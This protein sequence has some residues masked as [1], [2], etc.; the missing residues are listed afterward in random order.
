MHT[1]ELHFFITAAAMLL[2]SGAVIVSR[3]T[4]EPAGESERSSPVGWIPA[5]SAGQNLRVSLG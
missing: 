4:D 2:T 3:N 5:R 1:G